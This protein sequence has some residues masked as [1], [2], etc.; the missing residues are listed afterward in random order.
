[1]VREGRAILT[2]REPAT[3]CGYRPSIASSN[4]YH[5]RAGFVGATRDGLEFQE[6]LIY[7]THRRGSKFSLFCPLLFFIRIIFPNL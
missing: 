1:M 4:F 6:M 2:G 5:A 3:N 7:S